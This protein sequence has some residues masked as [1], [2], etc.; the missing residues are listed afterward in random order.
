[1]KLPLLIALVGL[2]QYSIPIFTY[3]AV[4]QQVPHNQG[5]AEG[6]GGQK[7]AEAGP[8]AKSQRPPD[9][10]SFSDQRTAEQKSAEKEQFRQ[11]IEIQRK[12]VIATIALVAVGVLQA[13]FLGWQAIALSRTLGA[14]KRQVEITTGIERPWVTAFIELK[15]NW[16]FLQGD[17]ALWSICTIKNVGRSP[18]R[19]IVWTCRKGY[20]EIDTLAAPDYGDMKD[21]I[22]YILPPGDTTSSI[23]AWPPEKLEQARQNRDVLYIFGFVIYEDGFGGRHETRFCFRY[24]PPFRNDKL[25]GFHVGGPAAY[26]RQT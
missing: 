15:N 10:A 2:T 13:L 4:G 11:N 7:G 5:I 18:A 22:P 19:I 25:E 26:N 3:Q 6:N 9:I 24:Y 14:I 20:A 16:P 8:A 17:G 21:L 1:M 23:I 12:L